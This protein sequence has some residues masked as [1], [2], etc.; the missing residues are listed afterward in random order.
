MCNS[1]GHHHSRSEMRINPRQIERS[2]LLS[3][4]E[5]SYFS[6]DSTLHTIV[7]LLLPFLVLI[8]VLFQGL[9]FLELIYTIAAD[10]DRSPKHC[11]RRRRRS[12]SHRRRSRR[13]TLNLWTRSYGAAGATCTDRLSSRIRFE[14]YLSGYSAP[15]CY[16]VHCGGGCWW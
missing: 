5:N 1:P 11:F 15:R 7:W 10:R 9:L 2:L 4:Q 14:C 3:L 8:V 6:A 13:R 16:I 12:V